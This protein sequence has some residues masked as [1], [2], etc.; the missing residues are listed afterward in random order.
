MCTHSV[1]YDWLHPG[2]GIAG[3][4][5]WSW[6]GKT[7]GVPLKQDQLPTKRLLK[8][9]PVNLYLPQSI[10]NYVNSPIWK[11]LEEIVQVI[12]KDNVLESKDLDELFNRKFVNP[13]LKRISLELKRVLV[14]S[15]ELR[16]FDLAWSGGSAHKFLRVSIPRKVWCWKTV[17]IVKWL[18]QY[19]KPISNCNQGHH[20]ALYG[21]GIGLTQDEVQRLIMASATPNIVQQE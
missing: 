20:V 11:T 21:R 13:E 2:S 18:T 17:D 14:A 7:A 16:E 8:R 12:P 19:V 9:A 15:E 3:A 6:L 4:T 1:L 10:S 5:D